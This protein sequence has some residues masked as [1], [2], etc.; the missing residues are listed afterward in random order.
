[1]R[2]VAT[3]PPRRPPSRGGRVG[4]GWRTS[5]PRS[6]FGGRP[7]GCWA[8][9]TFPLSA[10]VGTPRLPVQHP[11]I[12]LLAAS[13]RRSSSSPSHTALRDQL[14]FGASPQENFFHLRLR[15]ALSCSQ[16]FICSASTFCCEV[17][18]HERSQQPERHHHR[19]RSSTD[20]IG[21][22]RRVTRCRARNFLQPESGWLNDLGNSE[23]TPQR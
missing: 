23:H 17:F 19:I 6:F 18:H 3:D 21:G 12:Q 10:T 16:R 4:G 9:A 5:A 2:S 11:P 20:G 8:A 13:V 22:R 7:R 15:T 1:M 14:C